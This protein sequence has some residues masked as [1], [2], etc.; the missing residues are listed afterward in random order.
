MEASRQSA[1]MYCLCKLNGAEGVGTGS[2]LII[3][4]TPHKCERE[5]CSGMKS[6]TAFRV[7]VGVPFSSNVYLGLQW[8]RAKLDHGG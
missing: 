2:L 3:N 4:S 7:I 6:L 1:A 5:S 8:F